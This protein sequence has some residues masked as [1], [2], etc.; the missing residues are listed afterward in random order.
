MEK[1]GERKGGKE[2]EPQESEI[3]RPRER[4]KKEERKGGKEKRRERERHTGW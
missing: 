2:R 3:D 4:E 1:R